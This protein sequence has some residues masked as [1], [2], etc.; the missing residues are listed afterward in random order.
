P[1]W[2]LITKTVTKY[3]KDYYNFEGLRQFKDKYKPRWEPRYIG[4]ET[5]LR[6]GV[7]PLQGLTDTTLLISGG[8]GSFV[9]K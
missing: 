8:L 2:R 1:K 3:G 5:G 7:K 4:I 9:K 6:A